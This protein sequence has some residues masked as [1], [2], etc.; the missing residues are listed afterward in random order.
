MKKDYKELFVMN[1]YDVI[2][3]LMPFKP[4]Y[5]SV[6]RLATAS[7]VELG[8]ILILLKISSRNFRSM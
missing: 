3:L 2:E 8:L 6:A 1:E 5:V 4:E 7:I